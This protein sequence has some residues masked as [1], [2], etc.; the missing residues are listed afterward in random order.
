MELQIPKG[1]AGEL[2]TPACHVVHAGVARGGE[3]PA[4]PDPSY[5]Y[6]SLETEN[7]RYDASLEKSDHIVPES[8]YVVREDH[9]DI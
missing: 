5:T 1:R 3:S 2:P 4:M 6:Y 7:I 8:L 9:K